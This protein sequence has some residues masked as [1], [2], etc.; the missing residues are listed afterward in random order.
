[1]ELDSII[2]SFPYLACEYDITEVMIGSFILCT[3]ASC[4]PNKIVCPFHQ[5]N[6]PPGEPP[7]DM[8]PEDVNSRNS[9][10]V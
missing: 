1:M 4:I 10:I 2:H 7:Y 3:D 8:I 5:F 9:I 6:D